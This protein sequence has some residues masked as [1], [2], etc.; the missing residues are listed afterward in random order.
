MVVTGK[1]TVG[2]DRAGVICAAFLCGI[3]EDAQASLLVEED[4]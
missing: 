2:P 1:E 4:I 3:K